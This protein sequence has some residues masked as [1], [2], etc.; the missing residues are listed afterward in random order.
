MVNF[1][2]VTLFAV[3]IWTT[4]FSILNRQLTT[5]AFR[6]D[7]ARQLHYKVYTSEEPVKVFNLPTVTERDDIRGLPGCVQKKPDVIMIGVRKCGIG[8][9]RA[10]LNEHPDIAMEMNSDGLQYFNSRYERG[11]MWYLSQMPCSEPGQITVENSAQYFTSPVAPERISKFKPDM[12]L[13]VTLTNPIKR[14]KSDFMQMLVGRPQ[15][16]NGVTVEENAL[17]PVT[18]HV[19]SQ[20]QFIAKS[21][22]IKFLRTWLT[23]FNVS[24][25]HIVD[26][27]RFVLDPVGELRKIEKFLGI[28][29]YFTEEQFAFVENRGFFCLQRFS[30][31][32][33]IKGGTKPH[34]YISSSTLQKLK[35]FYRQYNEELFQTFGVQFDWE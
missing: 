35:D 29:N 26:G 31:V 7:F 6:M 21:M 5:V 4:L 16:L 17:H 1:S 28:R 11:W 27:D 12:K 22:Y 19:M 32:D 25:I 10:F 33:C 30:N 9:V 2:V 34:P 24:Q 8:S 18:G 13:I 20:K 14:M 23:H 3:A 15:D